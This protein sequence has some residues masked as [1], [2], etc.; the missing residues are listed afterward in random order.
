MDGSAVRS[1]GEQRLRL[2]NEPGH[3]GADQLKPPFDSRLS[4]HLLVKGAHFCALCV[5]KQR[6]RLGSGDV[7][8]GEFGRRAGIQ[9]KRSCFPCPFEEFPG[10]HLSLRHG[11]GYEGRLP[12]P[13]AGMEWV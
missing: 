7:G 11:H 3:F 1:L 13:G 12:P 2:T 4:A 10:I 8:L 5:I 6:E 9:E